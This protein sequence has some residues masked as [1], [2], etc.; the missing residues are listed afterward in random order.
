MDK[1]DK[2]MNDFGY[3]DQEWTGSQSRDCKESDDLN[4]ARNKINLM[5]CNIQ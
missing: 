5:F 4:C 2:A 1:E 3:N